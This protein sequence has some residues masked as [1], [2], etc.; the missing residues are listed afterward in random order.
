MILIDLKFCF[1][2]RNVSLI[3][4]F[5]FI[6]LLSKPDRFLEKNNC[7]QYFILGHDS[8]SYKI[9]FAIFEKV[10]ILQMDLIIIYI[11]ELSLQR[12]L[13]KSLWSNNNKSQKRLN[14]QISLEDLLRIVFEV[15]DHDYVNSKKNNRSNNRNI[16]LIKIRSGIV[17]SAVSLYK[18]IFSIKKKILRKSVTSKRASYTRLKIFSFKYNGWLVRFK[19]FTIVKR[20]N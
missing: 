13:L 18:L 7:K 3:F 9:I 16:N 6:L 5:A 14:F 17:T 1:S 20:S 4:F 2:N 15:S 12:F 11:K 19:A 8:G 10:I